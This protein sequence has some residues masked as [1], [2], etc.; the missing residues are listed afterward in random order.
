MPKFIPTEH[1]N[2]GKKKTLKTIMRQFHTSLQMALWK[3][4]KEDMC[5]HECGGNV[6]Y[7]SS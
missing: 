6:C 2:K 4:M 1:K 5:G 7:G 3:K